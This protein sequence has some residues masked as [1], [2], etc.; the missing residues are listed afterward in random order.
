[1]SCRF[2]FVLQPG[3][4]LAGWTYAIPRLR[5]DCL[6]FFD[7]RTECFPWEQQPRKMQGSVAL[8]TPSGPWLGYTWIDELACRGFL[9][10]RH[11]AVRG[12][13]EHVAGVVGNDV[14][15]DVDPLLVGGPDEVTELLARSEMRID[16]EEILDT[17][18]VVARLERD[19]PEDRAD[20][21]GGDAEPPQVAEFALQSFQRTALPTAA[22]AEP[23][24][25][26]DPPARPASA[27]RP[28]IAA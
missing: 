9:Y 18:A 12:V 2:G 7:G 3:C 19:L 24:V 4:I 16:V 10:R 6:R 8:S 11:V 22:G 27:P 26:I 13:G 21:Q 15:D 28:Y 14:E 5:D 20:P 25:I 1:M 17:V 23:R